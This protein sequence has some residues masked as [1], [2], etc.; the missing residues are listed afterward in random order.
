VA[1]ATGYRLT[2]MTGVVVRG[3]TIAYAKATATS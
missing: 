1:P 2:G 3:E